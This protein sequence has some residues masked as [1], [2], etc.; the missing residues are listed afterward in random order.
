MWH[1]LWMLCRS[2]DGCCSYPGM[3]FS[4]NATL[5]MVYDIQQVCSHHPCNLHT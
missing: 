3:P 1:L 5:A 4:Q 2:A